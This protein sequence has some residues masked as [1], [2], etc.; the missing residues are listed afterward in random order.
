MDATPA[1]QTWMIQSAP[2]ADS[3]PVAAY[4]YSPTTPA[5]GQAVSFDASS[6]TCADAPCTYSWADDGSDGAGGTQWPLG[7]GKTMTFTF[8]GVGVKNVRMAVT[9]ADG[10]TDSTMKS[11]NVV[12][13]A[14]PADTTAPNTTIDSGPSGTTND[15]TPT[16]TFSSSESGSTFQCQVDSGAWAGCASPWTTS[17]LSNGAHSIAVR[18]TD[19]AGNTDASPATRSFTVATAVTGQNLMG[20]S[21][22]QSAIDGG[23]SGSGEAFQATATGSGAAVALTIYV[24]GQNRATTLVAGLYRDVNGH[25]GTL[26]NKGTRSAPTA[27]AW[28]KVTIP[29]T[30]LAS[31]QKYWIAVMGTGGGLKYRDGAGGSNC[32]SESS[33]SQSMTT[34]PATWKSGASWPSCPLSGYATN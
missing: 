5:T 27:A 2:P 14:P 29:A 12:A 25:P 1:S 13:T 16:S 31:G 26:L 18:A 10:D 21:A 22:I 7:S 17:A 32:H 33:A 19:A 9:D 11:I 3:Q 30:S 8:Q 4:V 24:D 34:L 20:S 28:N 23:S 15:S 6:A